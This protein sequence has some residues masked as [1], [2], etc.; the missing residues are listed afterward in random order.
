MSKPSTVEGVWFLGPRSVAVQQVTVAPPGPHEVQVE[1]KACG[2]CTGDVHRFLATEPFGFP[3]LIGHEGTGVVREVG[4]AVEKVVPGDNVA[5]LGSGHYAQLVNTPAD[6]A[7][8]IPGDVQDFERWILEPVACVVN[9]VEQARVRPGDRVL[10]IGCGFMGLMLL[11]GL[12]RTL[13]AEVL[14]ADVDPARLELA[15]GFGADEVFLTSEEGELERL[16]THA[17][18]MGGFDVVVEAAGAKPALTLAGDLLRR[19]GT[20]VM[21]SW[22]HGTQEINSTQWHL[23]GFRVFNASPMISDDFAGIAERTVRLMERGVFDLEPLITHA[24]DYHEAQEVLETAVAR[25]DGYIKGVL[26]Y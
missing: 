1:I 18:D 3:A 12:K 22:H 6:R 10:L 11:Q 16:R 8:K 20:L 24:V 26:I 23:G 13:A 2:V 19:A 4:A 25:K 9:G 14:A 15:R 5:L 17:G 21:F 7:F